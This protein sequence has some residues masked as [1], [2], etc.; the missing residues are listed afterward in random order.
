LI[1]TERLLLRRPTLDDVDDARELYTDP[2]VMRFVGGMGLDPREAVETWI[3]RWEANGF[4][5]LVLRRREDGRFVGRAGLLVWDR[6]VWTPTTLPEAA[7]P[8]IELGWTLARAQWGNGYATE[9][10]LAVRQWAFADLAVER[11][12]SLVDVANARSERVA[13][14]LGA[15]PTETVHLNGYGPARVWLHPSHTGDGVVTEP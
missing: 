11:L 4:G 12:I 9:A 14:R 8:E 7:E 13:E 5:Q 1:E 3:A 2:E 6:A 10:A 15:R